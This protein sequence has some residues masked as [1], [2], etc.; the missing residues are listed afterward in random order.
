MAFSI[1]LLFFLL[2]WRE[3][4]NNSFANNLTFFPWR[5]CIKGTLWAGSIIRSNIINWRQS[6]FCL[7][8]LMIQSHE[9]NRKPFSAAKD[10]WDGFVQSKGLADIF[11]SLESQLK[12]SYQFRLTTSRSYSSP[13]DG[14]KLLVSS[15]P[16]LRFLLVINWDLVLGKSSS[17][18][19]HSR[20]SGIWPFSV[21]HLSWL[22][23]SRQVIFWD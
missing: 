13:E 16:L 2:L 19:G 1:F 6:K 18:F 21:S 4:I 8:I 7:T 15:N 5:S 14:L 9:R 23:H 20:S 22:G 11:Q 3:Y 12:N 17:G 10:F